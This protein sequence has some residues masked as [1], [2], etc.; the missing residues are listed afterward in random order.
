MPIIHVTERQDFKTCR[1]LWKYA[2]K[3]NLKLPEDPLNALWIGRGVHAGLATY[4]RG[5]DPLA[6]FHIWLDKK[7]PP[8]KRDAL[9]EES[10]RKLQEIITL[11]E[12]MLTN[13]KTFAERN[14]AFE[15]VAV[16]TPLSVLVPG[17]K[18]RLQGT[19]DLLIRKNNHLWVFD[20]KTCAS[21]VDQQHLDIDDQM[22][23]YQWLVWKTCGEQP[24]GAIYNELRKK[25][26]ATPY[27]LKSG[28][29]LSKDRSIDTTPD[30][31][32]KAIQEN[33]FDESDYA[34]VLARIGQNEFFRRTTIPRNKHELETF[35]K[36]LVYEA[37]EMT[38][39]KTPLY[40]NPNQL[41]CGWCDYKILCKA[42]NEG[43][44]V[45]SLREALYVAEPGRRI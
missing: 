22:T 28:K 12:T 23:A 4:Y 9:D 44:D 32:R 21:F 24:A 45:K 40:P 10:W 29:S 33:G 42:E 6:G 14:D 2:Y 35:G 37:R 11:S 17:T 20:H 38:S 7:L 39:K 26:P 5:G 8:H 31:Y 1:R 30:I 41:F 25:I 43:G 3:E 34:D 16:E 27:L 18:A 19:L 36:W 13:Y 15:V